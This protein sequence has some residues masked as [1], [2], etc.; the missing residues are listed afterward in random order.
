MS[1]AAAA[2]DDV[3]PCPSARVVLVIALGAG[4]A[5]LIDSAVVN[6]TAPAVTRELGAD[7]AA[8]QWFLASY[9]LTFG[10]G[11]V[12]AG[13]LG[14]AL[15][16]RGPLVVGLA[17]FL[18]GALACA[19]APV[20]AA[21]VGGR[22]VQGLG[23]GLISAQVMGLIQD[24]FHGPA[25]VRAFAAYTAAGATAA[26]LG[27]AVA[28]GLLT[29]LPEWLG[30][31][32]V[33]GISAPF[34]LAT[35]V[36]A[37]RRLPRAPRSPR[38]DDPLRSRA[39][40]RLSLDL[41]GVALLGTLVLLATLPVIDP[42]VASSGVPAVAAGGILVIVAL[43]LWETREAR[44]RRVP[45]FAPAL[46]RS[47]GFVSGNAVAAL[48]FGS[49][50][51]HSSAVTLFLLQ[52]AALG[53]PLT[54][55]LLVPAALVRI[56]ASLLSARAHARIGGVVVALGLGLQILASLGILAA[57][58]GDAPLTGL[59]VVVVAAE[60]VSGIATGLLEP[61]L[62]AITLG[63][64]PAALH[65]SAASFLQL[66]Q[67]FSATFCVALVSGL[68]LAGSAGAGVATV[69]REG[70][71]AALAVCTGLLGGA[72]LIALLPVLRRDS[73]ATEVSSRTPA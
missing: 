30:W 35:L 60:A 41:P 26:V 57:L 14:D 12:P 62:R 70:L 51:A 61:P 9:S 44:R 32:A 2:A 33:L 54:A 52:G 49:V 38:S 46:I 28:A 65:G 58:G 16:R 69:S 50:L 36:V 66:T 64:A 29:L 59:L 1:A 48:W 13:R 4:L 67:R 42:G 68:L 5:T 18:L 47:V 25:R 34:S 27:P 11:L 73:S 71:T 23:A 72:L 8:I 15:G 53:A 39:R 55:L 45:L 6:Y 10:L 17:L 63:F 3:T 22:V 24:G 21:A 20:V 43:V 40:G 7:T 31:R 19:L 37:L 56:A